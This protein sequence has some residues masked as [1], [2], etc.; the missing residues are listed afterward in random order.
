MRPSRCVTPLFF[1]CFSLLCFFLQKNKEIKECHIFLCCY[2][3]IKTAPKCTESSWGISFIQFWLW[4]S[5]QA[6]QSVSKLDTLLTTQPARFH[7]TKNLFF[8]H[9]FTRKCACARRNKRINKYL[10]NQNRYQTLR[11]M[12]HTRGNPSQN[13]HFLTHFLASIL[14]YGLITVD[15]Q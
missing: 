5:N 14:M 12:V 9:I 2:S 13:N 7:A 10:N 11:L 6:D 4:G 1:S 8:W 15:L 3:T